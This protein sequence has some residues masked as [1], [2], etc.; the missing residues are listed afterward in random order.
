M[1]KINFK[2]YAHKNSFYTVSY[3]LVR[4][5]DDSKNINE[6]ESGVNFIQSILVGDNADYMK[7]VKMTNIKYEEGS[8]FL[9]NFYSQNCQFL[10]SRVIKQYEDGT[11]DDEYLPMYDSYSQLI[12]NETDIYY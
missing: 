12:I 10:I 8:P 11:T 7:Y 3:K 2:V 4:L 5:N 9:M 1:E 6:I